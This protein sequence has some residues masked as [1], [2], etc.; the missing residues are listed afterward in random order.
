MQQ[1][2]RQTSRHRR[3]RARILRWFTAAL[4]VMTAINVAV[5]VYN[6]ATGYW[7]GAVVYGFAVIL[8]ATFTAMSWRLWPLADR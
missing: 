5:L 2:P 8:T 6:V 7:Y 4:A 3:A 1:P